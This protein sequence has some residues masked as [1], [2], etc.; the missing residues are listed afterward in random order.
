MI[1]FDLFIALKSL[2]KRPLL[3]KLFHAKNIKT[4]KGNIK[5]PKQFCLVQNIS[6]V[7]FYFRK[8]KI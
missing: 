4:K 1:K 2:K 8:I 6:F 3:Y 5:L 7:F